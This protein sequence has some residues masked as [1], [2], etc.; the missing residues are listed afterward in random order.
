MEWDRAG[1]PLFSVS[2][3]GERALGLTL[4]PLAVTNTQNQL[5]GNVDGTKLKSPL[6]TQGVCGGEKEMGLI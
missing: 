1:T 3:W 4:L 6:D 5:V 2:Q